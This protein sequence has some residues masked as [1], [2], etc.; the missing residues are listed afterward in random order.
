MLSKIS[1]CSNLTFCYLFNWEGITALELDVMILD[2]RQ[3]AR[4]YTQ[5]CMVDVFDYFSFSNFNFVTGNIG[6]L[7]HLGS[8]GP[9][10]RCGHSLCVTLSFQHS[11][12]SH[13]FVTNDDFL[14]G[15]C[16]YKLVME[17]RL[18]INFMK[19]STIKMF[20]RKSFSLQKDVLSIY[21]QTI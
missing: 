1:P 3:R 21:H 8:D 18:K 4:M 7:R 2:L 10:A 9:S 5:C 16:E 12:L 17:E 19:L 11:T 13:Q 20:F 14:F 6:Y 15:H